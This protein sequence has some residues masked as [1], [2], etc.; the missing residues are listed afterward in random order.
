MNSETIK[1]NIE[2]ALMEFNNQTIRD[3]ATTLL[4]TL[5]YHSGLVGSNEIDKPR[6]DHIKKTAEKTAN[7]TDRLCIE[8]W[9]QFSQILQVTDDE[10]NA[11]LTEETTEF[12]SKE[13]D[14]ELRSSYMF[15]AMPLAGESYTRTHLANIMR[16]MSM[17]IPQPFM[18]MFRYGSALTL[19][20]INRRQSKKD[21]NKQ[22]LEKVTLIKDIDL[23]SPKRAHI[24]I[25]YDLHLRKLITDKDR[26]VHNF[27]TL[28]DAWE[29]ILNTEELNKRFYKE[30]EVWYDWAIAVCKFPDK[31]NKMQVIRMLTRILFIWFLKEK[32]NLVPSDLFTEDGAKEY[33]NNFDY[34]S[35]DY[36]Q[37]IL[38][39]LFFATLNTPINEREFRIL[40]ETNMTNTEQSS[41][42]EYNED[43]RNSN[44]Y[45]YEDLIQNSTRFLEHL[46]QVPFVNGGLFDS[47]D[48][49][50]SKTAGGKRVDCFT[51][52]N[53]HRKKLSVPAKLFFEEEK[54]LYNIFKDY[55]FTVEE[56]TPVDQEVALDPELLGQVFEN[57]LGVYNPETE[58]LARKETG[59]FYTRRNVVD[60]M[61]DE[62][63]IAYLLQKVTPE[64]GDTD[65]FEDRLRDDLL[66][67]D[68]LGIKNKSNDHMIYDSEIEPIVQAVD[69]LKI[70]D[71]AVGSG[72]F[73]MGILNKLVLILKKL[74]PENKRWKQQQIDQANNIPD[75]TSRNGS[76]KVIDE[77]FSEANQYNNYGRKL[78]VIQNSI[79]G[80]DI[81]PIAVTIAKLRFFIS[82]VIEQDP[83]DNGD[84][85]YG[86]R[87]L[88]NLETKF[89][90]A[91]TLIG[92]M[93][94]QKEDL[95]SLLDDGNIQLLR[96]K[97]EEIRKKYFSE[98]DRQKKLDFIKEEEKDRSKLEEAIVNK[99]NELHN[100][101]KSKIAYQVNQLQNKDD[102]KQLHEKLEKEFRGYE[103]KLT[104]GVEEGKRIAKWDPYNQNEKS[105]F[106]D[107]EWMF[108]I[109][110]GFDITIGNPP[111]VRADAGGQDQAKKLQIKEMRQQIKDSKQYETLYE[112]WDLF[113]PFIER[114]YK[115]LKPDGFTTLIVSNAYCH[116]KYAQKS[117]NWFLENS[118]ILRLDFCG[119]VP[120]FGSVGVR[121]VI[122]LFQ[123]ADGRDNKPGRREH[124]PEFGSVYL[125]PTDR[126]QNLT[127]RAY[128]PED[129]DRP[130]FSTTTITLDKICYISVGMVV[131]A[132][133][134]RAEG[135]FGLKDVVS[136]EKDEFHPKPFVEGKYLDRWI[137]ATLRWL[138]W[139]TDRAPGLFRRRTFPEL[140]EADEKLISISMAAGVE[141]LRVIYDDQ[142]LCHNDSAYCFI[143]W[144]SLAGVRNRSIKQRTRYSDERPI[145]H[146]L[147]QRE[148]LEKTSCRFNLKYLLGVMNSTV[149]DDFLKANRRH[150]IRIYPDDWKKLPIPD[151]TSELQA[152]VV[153]LV[154]KILDAKRKGF[155]RKVSHLEKKLDK[156]VS[157]LY[158]IENTE[159]NE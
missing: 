67:Y 30:L 142:K 13:I 152:P 2:N 42:L 114:S 19:G 128:F 157:M 26:K 77:V 124:Y 68:Q 48:S 111:Y 153:A 45:R 93:Q 94:L 133:E 43:H 8:E 34:E 4:N 115:L 150:N 73:P 20:I 104:A 85:N 100:E 106:F 119:K 105:D 147:P 41:S 137:P 102:K 110:E 130:Q 121:N 96:Q 131:H 117:Q 148:E 21:D 122:Y 15:I 91:N 17:R 113:I 87:P 83:N 108:G 36:Y 57:L 145:R 70:L 1:R 112:K 92:L 151:V 29:I 31:E 49:F 24:E 62:A 40:N 10:I 134:K 47:L 84:D 56:N 9:E 18:V 143:P 7:P 63:L 12:E 126:Q 99:Y 23:D 82:L 159:S 135:E 78:Y 74:D 156:I 81:Q 66:A 75:P 37:A 98:N 50:K 118:K 59:S 32:N 149:A 58:D 129:T 95:Q 138:E 97:I 154:D 54:G 90:A 80:V 140:Y 39:N 120:L 64:D 55:K 116:A 28:H 146:D 27:D 5:G 46:K 103:A 52:W 35:S 44:K 132:D 79:Y 144:Q 101:E 38:Q 88:P 60:Y 89:V 11:Q 123:R 22:V 158:G 51:D 86:I 33:L 65:F 14:N 136:D 109:K 72:A 125:L 6:Y 141:K 16:F 107:P 69:D 139:G 25:V 53:N 3:A 61:V 76:L 71:P 127:L 155:E